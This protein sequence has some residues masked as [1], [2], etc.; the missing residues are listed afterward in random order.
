MKYELL[1][2]H[3]RKRRP[4]VVA[5]AVR[6]VH[7]RSGGY[8]RAPF[9]RAAPTRQDR[10]RTTDAR[11]PVPPATTASRPPGKS[12]ETYRFEPQSCVGKDTAA[13]SETTAATATTER[14]D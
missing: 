4:S 3:R 12:G 11:L 8:R 1:R 13:A 2:R 7:G 14:R 5:G 6:G 9:A 10:T